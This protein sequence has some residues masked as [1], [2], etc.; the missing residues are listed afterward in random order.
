[1]RYETGELLGRGGMGEVYRA[2]DPA[3]QRPVA[4][5][6]LRREDPEQIEGVP[7]DVAARS[8][9]VEQR[10]VAVRDVAGAVHAAHRIGLVHRDLKPCNILVETRA[11]V[12]RPYVT[13]FGLVRDAAASS[14][15]RTG[16]AIGT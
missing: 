2:F 8:M 5:K 12:Q 15:T 14:L 7:L 1:M 9:S 6:F 16:D 4:L 3:L 11:G 10:V 13:D